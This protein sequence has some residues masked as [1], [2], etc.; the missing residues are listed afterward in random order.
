[1]SYGDLPQCS[2]ARRYRKI[3]TQMLAEY[4][5]LAIGRCASNKDV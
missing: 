4:I 2:E 5:V 1:M 3:S